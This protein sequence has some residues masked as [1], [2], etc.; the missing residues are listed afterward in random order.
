MKSLRIKRFISLEGAPLELEGCTTVKELVARCNT[1][2]VT[3]H[4]FDNFTNPILGTVQFVASDGKT[5]ELTLQ[6]KVTPVI[7]KKARSK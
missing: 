5:Y 2:L 4:M 3:R 6:V 1:I 7:I